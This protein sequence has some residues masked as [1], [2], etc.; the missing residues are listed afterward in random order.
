MIDIVT[1]ITGKNIGDDDNNF[2]HVKISFGWYQAIKLGLIKRR[3]YTS[4]LYNGHL[5]SNQ[6]QRKKKAENSRR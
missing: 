3:V 5:R 1:F 2:V 6:I 4:V